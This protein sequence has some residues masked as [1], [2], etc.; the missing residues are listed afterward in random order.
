MPIEVVDADREQFGGLGRTHGELRRRRKSGATGR[1]DVGSRQRLFLDAAA[2]AWGR[3]IEAWRIGLLRA[4]MCSVT[5]QAKPLAQLHRTIR[6]GNTWLALQAAS[7]LDRVSLEDAFAIC[8]LLR[9]DDSRYDRACVRWLERFACEMPGV[10]LSD[11]QRIAYAFETVRSAA[12]GASLRPAA[13]VL[14]RHQLHRAAD[15]LLD[16]GKPGRA[17]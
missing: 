5:S 3:S 15:H 14:R 8:V 16:F 4:N 17:D 10:E 13:G 7:E 2:S 6:T 1:V 11:V 12:A 9:R